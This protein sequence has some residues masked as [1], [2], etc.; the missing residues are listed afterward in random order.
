MTIEDRKKII[1]NEFANAIVE[2]NRTDRNMNIFLNSPR[3]IIDEKYGVVYIPISR[4]SNTIMYENGYAVIPK[5]Y[6]LLDSI[7]LDAMG[8]S[9]V[10]NVPQ[11]GLLGEGV[12]LGFVDTGID[13]TNQIF[14]NS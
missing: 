10:Q 3:N 13:Y 8:V 14:K 4:I 12:L 2:Y 11:L 1:S 5:L 6:G 7:N 9:K